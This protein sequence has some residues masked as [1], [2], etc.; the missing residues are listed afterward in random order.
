[1]RRKKEQIMTCFTSVDEVVNYLVGQLDENGHLT[2][3]IP[4]EDFDAD[5]IWCEL[6]DTFNNFMLEKHKSTFYT[7]DKTPIHRNTLKITVYRGNY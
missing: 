7:A 1:M 2:I 3:E 4:M 5:V 6:N